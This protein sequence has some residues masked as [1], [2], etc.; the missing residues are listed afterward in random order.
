MV[1]QLGDVNCIFRYFINEPVFISDSSGPVA[2]KSMFKWF[3]FSNTLK[4]ISFRFLDEGIDAP[5]NL[6]IGFL[7]KDIII[8]GVVRKDE[9]H[10]KSSFSVPLSF[11]SWAIDS[12]KRLVFFGDLKR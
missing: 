6:F 12:I 3:R 9:L 2:G 8:P 4:W 7:P 11:S 1:A 10:S 5:K